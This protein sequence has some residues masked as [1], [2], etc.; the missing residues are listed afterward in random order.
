LF[1]EEATH[2]VR[3][4]RHHPCI[5]LWC[6]NNEL[7]QIG[8][9]RDEAK[10]EVMSWPE[11]CSLFD[12]LIPQV[13][14]E[15]DPDRPYWPSSEHSPIGDRTDSTNPNWGDA[16]LWAVWHGKKPFEWYRTTTHRFC[17]EFGFQSFPEPLTVASYTEPQDRNVTAPVMEHHQRSG[18]G[19]QT[20]MHYMLSWYRLPVG[21]ENTLWLSQ[22]QQGLAIKFAVEHWRRNMPR[23]MGALY[24]QLNDCWPVASWASIDSFGRWKALHYMAKRF[25]APVLISGV[26]KPDEENVEIHL[27]SDRLKA[28]DLDLKVTITD[29][30][31]NELCRETMDFRAPANDTSHVDTLDLSP[32]LESQNQNDI[33]VWLEASEDGELLSSN[34]VTFVH[35]KSMPLQDPQLETTVERDGDGFY[36][37]VTCNSP[38]LWTWLSDD[39][40]ALKCS[41]NFFC[42]APWQERR[43]RITPEDD[44]QLDDLRSDLRA[45]SLIDT[46]TENE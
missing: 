39:E 36:A 23:C 45:R 31:G 34:L 7:E 17:S 32:L 37:T 2:L 10:E 26:E 3:R 40:T 6:G 27:T 41:D 38:A 35:P 29:C 25:F 42:L 22:I 18:I 11:Y 33:L 30:A 1:L 16:H 13:L 46:Y 21:F 8:S 5:A 43:V 44:L 4:L 15:E 20:I 12:Q 14:G 9:T 24:W 28:S 19:N